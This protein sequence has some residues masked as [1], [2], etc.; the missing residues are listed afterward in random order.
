M[1]LTFFIKQIKDSICSLSKFNYVLV[2]SFVD[3]NIFVVC[4]DGMSC[5]FQVFI[6]EVS[7]KVVGFSVMYRKKDRNCLYTCAVRPAAIYGP[8]EERHLPRI[9]S[10]AKK[11]LL[12]FKVGDASV[13]TDWIYVD[14]LVL[15]L[16][17]AS[18]GLLDDIPGKEKHPVA[19]GQ[20]YFV[21]DGK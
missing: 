19:A 11:G 4:C 14:N 20:P 1:S 16:I 9:V 15:A 2:A 5:G 7:L 18:M 21:S 12:S 6:C 8:G 17:L 13:K 3:F 10:L